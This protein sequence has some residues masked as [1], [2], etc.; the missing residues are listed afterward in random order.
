LRDCARAALSAGSFEV[1]T[2]A[3]DALRQKIR[4]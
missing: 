2:A 3:V 4:S 1:F